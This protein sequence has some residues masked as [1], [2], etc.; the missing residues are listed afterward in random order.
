MTFSKRDGKSLTQSL[1][2]AFVAAE[3]KLKRVLVVDDDETVCDLIARM[4]HREFFGDVTVARSCAEA[5]AELDQA[6]FDCAILDQ[7]LL[8]G[9]GVDIYRKIC[10]IHPK[11]KVVFLTGYSSDTLLRAVAAIGTARV[12]PKD[13]MVDLDI[14]RKLLDELG[15]KRRVVAAD[16]I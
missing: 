8:N 10:A 14:T 15:L 2:D 5:R 4:V 6:E 9:H 11:T 13:Y 1:A 7:I 16:G 12:H 3:Q